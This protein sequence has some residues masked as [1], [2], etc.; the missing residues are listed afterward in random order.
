MDR[1][2]EIDDAEDAKK[3]DRAVGVDR[4]MDRA[5]GGEH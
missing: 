3:I 1:A 4:K 2:D 5:D